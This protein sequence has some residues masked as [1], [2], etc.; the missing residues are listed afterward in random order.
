[1]W[2]THNI[3][4]FG[5]LSIIVAVTPSFD[6]VF[7][8]NAGGNEHTDING[9]TFSKDNWTEENK[10]N[11]SMNKTISIS[12]VA[13]QDKIIY[14]S[15]FFT[16]NTAGYEM[17]VK[18]DGQ[19]LM[20]LKLIHTQKGGR[21]FNVTINKIHTVLSNLNVNLKTMVYTAYDEFVYF[22]VSNG[23]VQYNNESSKI[24]DTK[25]RVDFR[26][27]S[28]RASQVAGIVLLLMDKMMDDIPKNTN[29]RIETTQNH[30][31][32][33]HAETEPEHYQNLQI[34]FLLIFISLISNLIEIMIIM[35]I[36]VNFSKAE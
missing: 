5:Q 14:Q 30:K 9:I 8:V 7:A 1:M 28:G 32:H 18:H 6:V 26:H 21:V 17:P 34:P 11:F 24:V 2:I 23:Y 13:Q 16:F 22:S 25:I 3:L 4:L 31:H 10:Q 19:Y 20:V 27:V 12:N 36:F 33:Y 35:A 15:Y 29:N